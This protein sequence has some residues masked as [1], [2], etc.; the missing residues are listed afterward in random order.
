MGKTDSGL[1]THET[2]FDISKID[3]SDRYSAQ[4][5]PEDPKKIVDELEWHYGPFFAWRPDGTLYLKQMTDELGNH[6]SYYL[7]PD[8]SFCESNVYEGL[9]NLYMRSFFDVDGTLLAYEII[10]NQFVSDKPMISEYWGDGKFVSKE[11]FEAFYR[12]YNIKCLK[13]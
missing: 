11:E 10:Q 5:W 13:N 1:S 3:K 2:V 7:Y 4:Y 8:G 6:E 12:E 9:R